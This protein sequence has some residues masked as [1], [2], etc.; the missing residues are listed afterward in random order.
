MRK[1]YWGWTLGLHV[2]AHA[3]LG[4]LS[5][6]HLGRALVHHQYM[7][8]LPAGYFQRPDTDNASQAVTVVA[9]ETLNIK[10]FVY[11]LV[12]IIGQATLLQDY[13]AELHAPI[14]SGNT[15]RTKNTHII[16]KHLNAF[17]AH[18]QSWQISG[19]ASRHTCRT[20]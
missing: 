10:G 9:K 4:L 5:D 13:L 8:Q 6:I 16:R 7:L 15:P 11:L 2:P 18:P 17:F 19:L 12:D 3:K 1:D 14:R 20:S